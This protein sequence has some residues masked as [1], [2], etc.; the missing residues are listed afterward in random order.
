MYMPTVSVSIRNEDYDKWRKL[1]SPAE[2]IHNALNELPTT[3]K[4]PA[5]DTLTSDA[6]LKAVPLSTLEPGEF[7]GE[8]EQ[9]SYEEYP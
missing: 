8:P 3:T 9:E 7:D 5:V 6:P 1:D 4:V 2:F